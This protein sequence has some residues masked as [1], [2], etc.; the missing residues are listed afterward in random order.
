MSNKSREARYLLHDEVGDALPGEVRP[1]EEI[2][3]FSAFDPD[4]AHASDETAVERVPHDALDAA[5]HAEFGALETHAGEG[6]RGEEVEV[7]E[8]AH[9]LDKTNDPV[10]LY[11]REMGSVPLL[12]REG[13]VALAK[14]I[15]RGN[16]LVL[17]TIS[18]SPIILQDLIGV[19]RK[20]REGTRSIKEVI[21]F[22]EE[23]LTPEQLEDKTRATLRIID[24]IEK[25]YATGLK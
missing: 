12:K 10:R 20:L 22:G 2:G 21:Q 19:A 9:L 15:E 5:D 4:G 23:E 17:K 13:E 14:R 3:I 24:R 8:T 1:P 25:L 6:S 11:L 16:G 7:D 18:R